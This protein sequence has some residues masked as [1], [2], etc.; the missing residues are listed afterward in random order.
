MKAGPLHDEGPEGLPCSA[1]HIRLG[2]GCPAPHER[3]GYRM[4]ITQVAIVVQAGLQKFL[5]PGLYGYSIF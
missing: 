1:E 3:K 4:H 5:T 2:Q